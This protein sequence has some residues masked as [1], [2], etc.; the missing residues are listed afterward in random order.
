MACLMYIILSKIPYGMQITMSNWE[1]PKLK[2]QQ[3]TYAALD[4][5]IAGAV[6]RAL[7]LWHSLPSDCSVCRVPLGAL[8][9][10]HGKALPLDN[11]TSK[12][13]GNGRILPVKGFK[14]LSCGRQTAPKPGYNV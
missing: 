3:V 6:F 14:C 2:P 4:A 9:S 12:A 8:V 7:R 1:A 10:V 11:D 5:L 13:Q